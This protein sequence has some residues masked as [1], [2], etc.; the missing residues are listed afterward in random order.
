MA[1][2][3]GLITVAVG[4]VTGVLSN[5]TALITEDNFATAAIDGG[6]N[7][8]LNGGGNLRCYTDDTKAVQIPIEVITFVTG[9]APKVRVWVLNP[10][11]QDGDTVYIEADT[12][13]TSQPIVTN[14][15]GRN[16]VWV[17]YVGVYH[18]YDYTDSSGNADLQLFNGN[19]AP[20]Q[21]PSG[22]GYDFSGTSQML[23]A[24][25]SALASKLTLP[26]TIQSEGEVLA[27]VSD[28]L[29]RS[30]S[31][32]A[33]TGAGGYD[34]NTGSYNS[35]SPFSSVGW[36]RPQNKTSVL[37]YSPNG[38]AVSLG[39]PW[40]ND[41]S[42]HTDNTWT[43]SGFNSS[44]LANKT[45]S[46]TLLLDGANALNTIGIGGRIDGSE[47]YVTC[48]V[49]SVR[50][51]IKE[52]SYEFM[53]TE[54]ANQ[55]SPSTFWE[56]MATWEDQ[57]AGVT[58]TDLIFNNSTFGL[59]SEQS[60]LQRITNI[61]YNDSTFGLTS[62][63]IIIQRIIDLLFNSSTF[64]LT[65][66]QITLRGTLD[67]VFNSSTFGMTSEQITLQRITNIVYNDSTF[68]LTSEQIII[69]RIVDLLF[70]DSTFG[71]TSESITLSTNIILEML[72][73]TFGMTSEQINLQR[74]T[75]IEF[76]DSTFG[77]TSEQINLQ[78]FTKVSFNN[79][80]FG[81][82][83]D[84]ITLITDVMPDLNNVNALLMTGTINYKLT[85]DTTHY[86]FANDTTHYKLTKG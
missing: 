69:Q 9:G 22:K 44:E 45:G 30:V 21:L 7:S 85:N 67:L 62:E 75:N 29:R 18:L 12:V 77:L 20:T 55:S 73:S 56:P 80:T 41:F 23:Y 63:S 14:T 79:S 34:I 28:S 2:N 70:N 4:K 19:A 11:L 58:P 39:D 68:G 76:S 25:P 37:W 78:R 61:I 15:Y 74:F 81:L 40:R 57:D 82:T 86:K 51:S 33:Q 8:I 42:W 65:S 27:L 35:G 64:G 13:A 46:N 38:G 83:S 43:L 72:N 66:D 54:R 26:Y 16:S 52:R 48:I 1:R 50:V 24:Q 60:T 47:S 36:G 17:D 71:L 49:T 32:G 59:T 5:F 10:T 84:M 3:G 6:A 31:L 53:S